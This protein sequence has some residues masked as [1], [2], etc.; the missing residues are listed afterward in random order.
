MLNFYAEIETKKSLFSFPVNSNNNW[1]YYGYLKRIKNTCFHFYE[2]S[3][4]INFKQ[5]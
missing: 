1:Y 3:T 4:K 5:K 2:I